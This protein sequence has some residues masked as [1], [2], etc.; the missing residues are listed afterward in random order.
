MPDPIASVALHDSESAIVNAATEAAQALTG[1]GAGFAAV[2]DRH[3]DYRF[4]VV[5][6]VTDPGWRSVF[7]RPEPTRGPGPLVLASGAP[8]LTDDYVTDSARHPPWARLFE[9]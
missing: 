4:V 5:R 9:I 2:R 8:R 6:G 1:V 3:G 7:T